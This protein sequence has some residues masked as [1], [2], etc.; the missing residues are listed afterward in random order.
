METFDAKLYKPEV[1]QEG[2][3]KGISDPVEAIDDD[4]ILHHVWW[5]GEL[6]HEVVDGEEE[7]FGSGLKAWRKI[8][9]EWVYDSEYYSNCGCV[10][11]RESS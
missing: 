1:A 7:T 4:G 6:W 11:R 2:T 9:K 10:R 3:Y 5:D 8:P